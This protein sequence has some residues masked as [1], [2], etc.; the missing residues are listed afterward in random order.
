VCASIDKSHDPKLPIRVL[1]I[2][3]RSETDSNGAPIRSPSRFVAACLVAS[4]VAACA[5]AHPD[6]SPA[7]S[8]PITVTV[9]NNGGLDVDIYAVGSGGRYHLGVVPTDV[10]TTIYLPSYIASSSR[11]RLFVQPVSGSTWWTPSL[12][13]HPGDNTVLQLSSPPQLSTFAIDS[14]Y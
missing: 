6:G 1:R 4:Q 3:R 7:P 14:A 11:L 9:S 12:Q 8:T 5:G 2:A 13:V 10:T